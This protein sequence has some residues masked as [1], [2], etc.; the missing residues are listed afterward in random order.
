MAQ[1]ANM[2]PQQAFPPPLP[3]PQPPS[4]QLTNVTPEVIAQTVNY[5]LAL[6]G[7]DGSTSSL[8]QSSHA[9]P[10][11]GSGNRLPQGGTEYLLQDGTTPGL[12]LQ[13]HSPAYNQ[14]YSPYNVSQLQPASAGGLPPETAFNQPFQQQPFDP[15]NSS[16]GQVY[17]FTQGGGTTF[18][19]NNGGGP[20][21]GS[22]NAPWGQSS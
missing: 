19:N 15:G 7:G 2:R 3:T 13:Q 17:G 8:A 4:T 21:S 18:D 6:Q 14:G 10:A 20:S 5:F 22:S 9:G 16:E 1:N 11:F 12:G